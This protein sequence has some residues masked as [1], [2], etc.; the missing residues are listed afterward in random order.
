LIV[1][2][3]IDKRWEEYEESKEY[4]DFKGEQPGA[5]KP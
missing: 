3:G 1:E 2:P 4:Q 5:R